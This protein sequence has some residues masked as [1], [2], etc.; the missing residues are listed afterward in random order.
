MSSEHPDLVRVLEAAYVMDTPNDAWLKGLVEAMRPAAED[1]LGMAAYLYATSQRPF[2]IEPL[3]HDS[4]VDDAGLSM[5]MDGAHDDFVRRSWLTPSAATASETPGY[6]T[7]PG[8]LQ[9]FHPAGIRDVL[10]VN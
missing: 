8:V 4:P 1:G 7:H 2:R 9:V 6:D 10:V 5:L 3:I